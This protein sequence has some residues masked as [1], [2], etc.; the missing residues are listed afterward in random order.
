VGEVLL[1]ADAYEKYKND[2]LTVHNARIMLWLVDA[3]SGLMPKGDN[4]NIEPEFRNQLK[5]RKWLEESC[6]GT[7]YIY[8]GDYAL[9]LPTVFFELEEDAVMFKLTWC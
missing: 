5:M 9:D 3:K 1:F 2:L 6:Q 4:H 7:V 8:L